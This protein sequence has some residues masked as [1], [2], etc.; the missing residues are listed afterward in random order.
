M[1]RDLLA[2]GAQHQCGESAAVG[3]VSQVIGGRRCAERGA[4]PR[5]RNWRNS[6]A[7]R[8]LPRKHS[9]SRFPPTSCGA[10]SIFSAICSRG[11]RWRPACANSWKARTAAVSALSAAR[12][13]GLQ[14]TAKCGKIETMNTLERHHG[15]SAASRGRSISRC[16]ASELEPDDDFF[17]KLGINSLQALDLL[18]RIE[19]HFHIELPDY[20]LQ[21][22]SD[23]RTLAERNPVAAFDAGPPPIQLPRRSAARG[24]GSLAR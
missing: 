19:Q 24:D 8:R 5:P 11:R 12:V 23:F 16:R 21:G 15:R 3:L 6:T 14:I 9:S 10:K 18:T 22:V 4:Q 1:V 13:R 17:K 20:E 2:D 7:T